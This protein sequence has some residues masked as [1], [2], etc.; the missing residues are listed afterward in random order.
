MLAMKCGPVEVHARALAEVEAIE[1]AAR[2]IDADMDWGVIRHAP[3]TVREA[4]DIMVTIAKD[5]P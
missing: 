4:L 2:W 3:S 1:R 5:A